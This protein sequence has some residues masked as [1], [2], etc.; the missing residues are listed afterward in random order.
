MSK[1]KEATLK[2]MKKWQDQFEAE[3]EYDIY[4]SKVCSEMCNL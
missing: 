4:N 1:I 3:F 2:T